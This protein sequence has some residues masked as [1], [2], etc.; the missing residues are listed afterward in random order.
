MLAKAMTK[1]MLRDR[2]CSDSGSVGRKDGYW[3]SVMCFFLVI[4]IG[5]TPLMKSYSKEGRAWN[6]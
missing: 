5:G 2:S 6:T 4:A 3:D 1:V